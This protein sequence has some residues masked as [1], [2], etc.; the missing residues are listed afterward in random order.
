MGPIQQRKAV[1]IQTQGIDE[2]IFSLRWSA[3]VGKVESAFK[4]PNPR[5]QNFSGL[6]I[7]CWEGL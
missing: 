4:L 6:R 7:G 3:N 2:L 5:Y 1:F